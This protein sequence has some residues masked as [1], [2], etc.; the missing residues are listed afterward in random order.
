[1]H[2]EESTSAF[3]AA[4]NMEY[5]LSWLSSTFGEVSAWSALIDVQ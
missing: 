1:M 4:S 5:G 3:S 2:D